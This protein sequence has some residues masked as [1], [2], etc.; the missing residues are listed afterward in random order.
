MFEFLSKFCGKDGAIYKYIFCIFWEKRVCFNLIVINRYWQRL[1]KKGFCDNF[2]FL[3]IIWCPSPY[4]SSLPVIK[5]V[6]KTLA[7]HL[8]WDMAELRKSYMREGHNI[9]RKLD[10]ST[11][12]YLLKKTFNFMNVMKYMSPNSRIS[13]PSSLITSIPTKYEQEFRW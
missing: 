8:K 13:H 2:Q 9:R 7:K 10:I 4:H 5:S 1:G 3:R 11:F 6:A 12:C